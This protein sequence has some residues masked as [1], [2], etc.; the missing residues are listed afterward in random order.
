VS[1]ERINVTFF[2]ESKPVES[3]STPEGRSKNRRVEFKILKP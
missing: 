1:V 3:N 2:G